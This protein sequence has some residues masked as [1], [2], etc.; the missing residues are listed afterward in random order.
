MNW[1]T[2]DW[3]WVSVAL[4]QTSPTCCCRPILLRD[5][6]KL[7]ALVWILHKNQLIIK[8]L[9]YTIN[10]DFLTWFPTFRRFVNKLTAQLYILQRHMMKTVLRL[11]VVEK[12]YILNHSLTVNGLGINS[13]FISFECT[14]FG[15]CFNILVPVFPSSPHAHPITLLLS[16]Q[17]ALWRRRAFV[18]HTVY[19]WDQFR[20][21]RKSDQETIMDY[22]LIHELNN[23]L[24]KQ[25]TLNGLFNIVYTFVLTF[26][27]VLLLMALL[28]IFSSRNVVNKTVSS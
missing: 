14:A 8:L 13:W 25:K 20:G 3:T 24:K 1:A 16:F 7:K 17:W 19:N 12:I 4:K 15:I 6:S 11:P 10:G 18:A 23:Y 5:A 27:T 22:C 9:C 2:R 26:S 28:C 21:Q